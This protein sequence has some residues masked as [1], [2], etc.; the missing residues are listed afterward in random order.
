MATTTLTAGQFGAYAKQLA[1]NTVDTVQFPRQC[2][3]EVWT[4]GTEA[5]YFTVDGSMP[6][7]A[8]PACWE[9]PAGAAETRVLTG[10]LAGDSAGTPV[11]LIS[12]GTPKYSVTG[13]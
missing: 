7:V 6:T 13:T 3:I 4:D 9:I 2:S 1:A 8:G 11:K 5:V 10:V 12:A